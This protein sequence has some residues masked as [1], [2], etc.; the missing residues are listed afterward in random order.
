MAELVVFLHGMWGSGDDFTNFEEH[1]VQKFTSTTTTN[2]KIHCLRVTTN[3]N[4]TRD[5]IKAGSLRG[6]QYSQQLHFMLV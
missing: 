2:K 5:G 4:K 1:L 6:K 3:R